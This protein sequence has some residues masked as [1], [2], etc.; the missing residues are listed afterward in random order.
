MLSSNSATDCSSLQKALIT[1]T[2]V[3]FSIVSLVTLSSPDC[4]FLKSGILTSII[5]NITTKSTGIVT[6]NTMAHFTLIVKAITIA[7]IT[8]NGLL[9]ISRKAILRPFCTKFT[10]SVSLVINVSEPKVSI[11]VKERA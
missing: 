1:L 10:S 7:P 2:P 9:S 6:T 3:R 8:I 5:D 4:T 11:S